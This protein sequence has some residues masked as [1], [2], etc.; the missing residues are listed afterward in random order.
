MLNRH[1][2]AMATRLARRYA[3]R[4]GLLRGLVALAAF[5]LLQQATLAAAPPS[6]AQAAAPRK[7]AS[8][9]YI[10]SEPLFVREAN[11]LD[12]VAV[13]RQG[14]KGYLSKMCEPW[15]MTSDLQPMLRLYFDDR[16]LPW[17]SI[18][19][20]PVD[21]FDVNTRNIGAHAMLHVMLGKEKLNDAVEAGQ[22]AY[23]LSLTPEGEGSMI[24][25]GEI[26]KN[27]LLLHQFTGD[28]R[29]RHWAELV[30]SKLQPPV[31]SSDPMG[32]WLHLHVG[33]NIGALTK[34]YALSGDRNSLTLAVACA[35]RV[36]KSRDPNGDDGAF[37]PDGSFGGKS[38]STTASWHMH[39]HTHILP[40][41]LALG[42]QLLQDKN[43]EKGRQFIGQAKATF[44]WL[45]DPARNPDAGSMTGWLGEWLMVATT[46]D[47][48]SDCEGCTMGDTVE[49]AVALGAL[50]RLRPEFAS[51]ADYFDRAEQIYR[52]QVM[53]SVFEPTPKYLECLRKCLEQRVA[54]GPIGAVAWNDQSPSGN[55]AALV[56]GDVKLTQTGGE[57]SVAHSAIQFDG[58]DH[59]KFKDSA[60]LRLPQFAIYAVVNVTGNEVQTIYSNYDNPINWGKGVN[61]GVTADRRVNFFTTDGTEQHYDQLNSAAPLPSGT[62]LV[63][64]IYNNRRKQIFIDGERV[65]SGPAK[66][67]DYGTASVAAVGALREFG[68]WLHGGIA[69]LIVANDVSVKDQNGTERQL[70]KK[71]GL[72]LPSRSAAD[73]KPATP[74]VWLKADAGYAR[75]RPEPTPAERAKE[76]DRL[77]QDSLV[78]AARLEG[79]LLG[80]SGFGDW[81]NKLPS[82]LDPAL[83]GVDM[84]GCCSDA[85][86]RASFAVWSETVSGDAN[87]TRVNM[88]FNR[89]SPL[90]DVVSCLPHRGEVDI[91]VKD[92]RRVLVRVPEW[93]PREQVGAFVNGKPV[94]VSWQQGYVDFPQVERGQQ[95]TVTYPLRIAEIKETVGSLDG[96]EYT[97]KWRGNTIVDISPAGRL[98]PMYQRPELDSDIIP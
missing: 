13:S 14:W 11:T 63:T 58:S 93:A 23:V 5:G 3:L 39:G 16:A 22:L 31:D 56:A 80:L 35:E 64:A 90:V 48:Q 20:N 2:L 17:P 96:T 71:Y 66:G 43:E 10:N 38:Q 60:A 18:K 85:V 28:D 29:Y 45:Y 78:T 76:V 87:E 53:A 91:L 82:T 40:G 36:C 34:W 26:A 32:G 65:A 81:V 30:I 67:L 62:H 47:R 9:V 54:K 50:S 46:W 95:L 98:V 75:E 24:V 33:W 94:A 70:A 73:A 92:S 12:P 89:Q 86:I 69:E 49:T 77:Y 21:G 7:I 52:G 37:R 27:L 1:T 44:D 41:L 15:G 51:Y 61:L 68:Q 42:E 97:E 74:A 59:L 79:R 19:S 4:G 6:K 72:T 83:P 88:A 84:M 8:T 57:Y 25:H 55:H